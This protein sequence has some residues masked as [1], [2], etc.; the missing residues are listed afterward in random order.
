[1][2]ST[3]SDSDGGSFLTPVVLD[4]CNND[5]EQEINEIIHDYMSSTLNDFACLNEKQTED[6][7]SSAEPLVSEN[8]DLKDNVRLKL[9]T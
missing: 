3:Q 9:H 8:S 5:S 2:N 6:T 1:M 7:I 4:Y